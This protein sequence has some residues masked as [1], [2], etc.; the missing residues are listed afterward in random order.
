MV[1]FYPNILANIR[2]NYI[3]FT[4]NQL[5]NNVGSFF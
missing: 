2:E 1:I 4:T 5:M 3:N